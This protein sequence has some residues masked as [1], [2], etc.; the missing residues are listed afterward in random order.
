MIYIGPYIECHWKKVTINKNRRSCPKQLCQRYKTRYCTTNFCDVCGTKIDNINILETAPSVNI[1]D[2]I[3]I[4]G[5]NP[6]CR[7]MGDDI[8]DWENKHNIHIW[9]LNCKLECDGYPLI[10]IND[11]SVPIC[12]VPSEMPHEQIESFISQC[13]KEIKTLNKYY[14]KS[15]VIYRWGIINQIC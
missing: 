6:L 8:Y 13:T 11:A 12:H 4:I 3:D 14:N 9:M 7:P 15:N 5:E 2:I 1:Y 10:K